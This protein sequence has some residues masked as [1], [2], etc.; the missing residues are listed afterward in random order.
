MIVFQRRHESGWRGHNSFDK[1]GSKCKLR[2]LLCPYR[3]QI[4][5]SLQVHTSRKSFGMFGGGD[6]AS[7]HL[8]TAQGGEEG[9]QNDVSIDS[10]HTASEANKAAGGRIGVHGCSG[11][12]LIRAQK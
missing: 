4:W 12:N 1:A 8:C 11:M 10:R 6:G 9:Q 2:S 3:A 7:S 5:L